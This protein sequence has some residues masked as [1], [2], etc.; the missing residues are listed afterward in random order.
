MPN[1]RRPGGRGS[2]SLLPLGG[3]LLAACAAAPPPGPAKTK[4][5][6]NGS[7]V[8]R[9]AADP[10][11]PEAARKPLR[12]GTVVPVEDAPLELKLTARADDG[13]YEILELE[14]PLGFGGEQQQMNG[15]LADRWA[16]AFVRLEPATEAHAFV[17]RDLVLRSNTSE[18]V[19]E[20]WVR[21]KKASTPV[22]GTVYTPAFQAPGRRRHIHAALDAKLRPDAKLKPAWAKALAQNLSGERD[23]AN[24]FVTLRLNELF[25]DTKPARRNTHLD[26][27]SQ[28]STTLG[29]LM[30]T[31]TGRLS[32]Q[33]ALQQERELVLAASHEPQSVPLAK[34][35]APELAHH[36]WA[37]LSVALN[38]PAPDEP[39]ARAVPAE[40][41]FVRARD[42]GKFLDLLDD[43]ET[44][45]EPAA[46]VLDGH[47]EQRGT[48]SRYE[49]ELA[50]ERT[51]LT[52]ILGP[53]VVAELALTGSDPYLHEG[54]D[55][56]LIFRVKNAALFSSA[57]LGSLARRAEAHPG[58]KESSFSEDGVTV[59]VR[60]SSDG[61]VRQHRATLGDL[62]LVSNSPNAIRRVIRTL[63]GKQPNLAAELD[64]KYMLARDAAKPSDELVYFG[65]RF[66][67]AVVG[68]AQK[69]AEA[70]RQIALS[71]LSTP[72]YAALG[73]GLIDGRTPKTAAE[74]LKAGFLKPAE[75]KHANGTTIDWAPGRAAQSSY[76]TP[77]LLE[78]LLDLPPVTRVSA[79][80][81]AGY[82]W[83]ARSYEGTWSE[84][85]D[86]IA[87]RLTHAQGP[88]GTRIVDADLRVLPTLRRE[89]WQTMS[90]VGKARLSVPTLLGGLSGVI[91]LG[92]EASLRQEL[93]SMGR[94]FGAGKRFTFDW[95]GDYALLGVVS[96]N[97][98]LNV[99][100]DLLSEEIEVPAER[101]NSSIWSHWVESVAN[102]PVY[103]AIGV[104]S[105]VAASVF[106]AAARAKLHES[107]GSGTEW[108][109]AA[110]YRGTDVVTVR[111]RERGV[112]ASLYYAL[113]DDA[114]VLSLSESVLHLALDQLAEHP[115]T[116]LA[117]GKPEPA[118]AG[119]VVVELSGNKS[120]ALFTALGWAAS[121]AQKEQAPQARALAKLVL[122]GSPEQS[123]DAKAVRELMRA[124]LGTVVVTPDGND[125][126]L[127]PDGVRDPVRGTLHAPIYPNLPVP[128]SPL[129]EVLGRLSRVRSALS[130]DDE[131]KLP[132]QAAT[133]QPLSSLHARVTLTLK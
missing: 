13:E 82:E 96:R 89:Y 30:D 80:E 40:F 53:Q 128:G 77:A 113:T 83:F 36:P 16:D 50:L 115:P 24:R 71:E 45:G 91:G 95:L 42:F 67:A 5:A 43:V 1:R 25:V 19:L 32:V 118:D 47:A 116:S 100:R 93:T 35:H 76:G 73:L 120:D 66:V 12:T 55:V 61:R 48:F 109:H 27:A 131:P 98:L 88:G 54:S 10:P 94:M 44:F 85:I 86:P 105:R 68:P 70:R 122:L 99:T 57:L 87:L 123:G 108:D 102:F 11:A 133:N 56:T 14:L 51:A 34:V 29:R 6:S 106:L 75:L 90:T 7:A 65:D 81:Q 9:E 26:R 124:Y 21:R 28:L 97:E 127:A 62:E 37:E 78:P 126:T 112:Q 84:R 15:G 72:G 74:V 114:L 31:T 22:D 33:L 39:L 8:A 92:E 38:R 63:H 125:Y 4:P 60:R 20:L 49:T 130:F 103:A 3:A 59:S 58:I 117:E 104:R 129:D 101:R 52:R 69:I 132:S 119:Q 64:F 107:A 110:P 111:I 121:S 23:V 41:Y 17:H 79:A 2:W 46:D 18:S